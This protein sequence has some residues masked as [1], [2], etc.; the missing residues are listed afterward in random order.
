MTRAQKA[1]RSSRRAKVRKSKLPTGRTVRNTAQQ[2][3]KT[4]KKGC[5]KKRGSRKRKVRNQKG[6]S[7]LLIH[8]LSGLSA[9]LTEGLAAHA[10]DNRKKWLEKNKKQ[11]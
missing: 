10:Q 9:G 7:D 11:N 5:P 4:N 6:G 2:R 3:R 8:L 1:K